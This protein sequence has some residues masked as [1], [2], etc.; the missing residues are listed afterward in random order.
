MQMDQ[1]VAHRSEAAQVKILI[2]IMKMKTSDLEV[3]VFV[4]LNKLYCIFGFFGWWG[5]GIYIHLLPYH[6][7]NPCK[8][9][10]FRTSSLDCQGFKKLKKIGKG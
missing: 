10:Q 4:F 8:W 6:P 1:L 3:S 9:D 2:Q 7:S 5:G